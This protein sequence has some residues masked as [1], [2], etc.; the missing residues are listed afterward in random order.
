VCVGMGLAP[1]TRAANFTNFLESLQ[2]EV[3][4]RLETNDDA[5]QRR[6]LTAADKALNP[7][8][9]AKTLS[10]DLTAFGK[11]VSTL[12]KAFGEEDEALDNAENTSFNQFLGEADAQYNAI[13]ADSELHTNGVPPSLSNA[14]AKAYSALTNAQD[15]TNWAARV[16]ALNLALVKIKVAQLQLNKSL[17]APASIEEKTVHVDLNAEER[18]HFTLD[19][20]GT[21]DNGAGETGSWSYTRTSANTG[22][23]T[24]NIDGGGSHV[25]NV[26]FKNPKTGTFT[27]E[28]EEGVTGKISIK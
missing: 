28:G 21:Y 14:L 16:R 11:A 8:K 1:A 22:T 13:V 15:N 5:A 26:T 10:Q 6:A 4:A 23:I 2:A 27:V 18:L 12:N 17:K 19:P 24:L 7:T 25:Y 20:A 3:A 9:D